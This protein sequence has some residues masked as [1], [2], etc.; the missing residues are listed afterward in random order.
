MNT[1]EGRFVA[2]LYGI[3]NLHI[4]AARL[5]SRIPV[6][7]VHVLISAYTTLY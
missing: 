4:P 2:H 3:Y 1:N 5:R 6:H 7:T